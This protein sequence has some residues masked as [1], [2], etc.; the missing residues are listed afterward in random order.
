MY[1]RWIRSQAMASQNH[2]I[3][4]EDEAVPRPTAGSPSCI[5]LLWLA[6]LWGRPISYPSIN[7]SLT[8]TTNFN[9][10]DGV[11]TS[12]WNVD[13]QQNTI[14]R[15]NL[16]VHL[17]SHHPENL[18]SNTHTLQ[19]T[20]HFLN[21]YTTASF[22]TRSQLQDATPS[23]YKNNAKIITRHTIIP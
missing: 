21:C 22:C 2:G 11:S 7:H 16:D 5:P 9:P 14:L 23:C 8:D 4:S 19:N 3:R 13:I 10:D 20:G 6:R 12:L 15:N 17:Y 18:K 1:T